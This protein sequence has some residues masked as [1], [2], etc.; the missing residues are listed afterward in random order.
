MLQDNA[1][2][3][4]PMNRIII[5]RTSR[6]PELVFNAMD[7]DNMFDEHQDQQWKIVKNCFYCSGY[8]YTM[9]YFNAQ[10]LRANEFKFLPD[11]DEM[12]ELLDSKYPKQTQYNGI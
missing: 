12:M 5:N 11:Q 2:F 6:N 7:P 8:R 10:N 3:L 4:N 9:V 1:M